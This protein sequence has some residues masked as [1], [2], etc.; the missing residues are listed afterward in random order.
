MRKRRIALALILV[1]IAILF[2][3]CASGFKSSDSTAADNG[4][5]YYGYDNNAPQASASEGYDYKSEDSYD[6]AS[7]EESGSTGSLATMAI[8]S[9]L[10]SSRKIILTAD[11]NM[12]T[13]AFDD[14]V[15]ALQ[16]AVESLGG[17][18]SGANTYVYNSTY[19]LRS[20]N[21]TV[22]IPVENFSAFITKSEQMGNVTNANIWQDDVTARYTDIET[23]LAALETKKERLLAL[24]EQATEMSDIIELESALSDTIYQ[25]ES[26]TGQRNTYDD[27]IRYSTAHVYIDEVRDLTDVVTPPKTL[28]ERIGQTFRSSW[29]SF[30]NFCEDALVFL[31]GALPVLI[32]LV[33]LAVALILILR[34]TAPRRAARREERAERQRQAAAQYRARRDAALADAA[35]QKEEKPKS[36][37]P[38]DR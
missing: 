22:R 3:G 4:S 9:A 1:F 24:M 15:A 10:Q 21:Y 13:K 31:V 27:Q 29:K 38:E 28:G 36:D 32:I 7:M 18:I 14:S 11:I 37:K 16:E 2:S 5:Y 30:V 23:R 35:A 6:D 33:I 25:I 8:D 20:A 19:S 26:L 12:E 17:Y 34:H